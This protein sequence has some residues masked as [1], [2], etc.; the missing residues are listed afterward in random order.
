M[1]MKI[2]KWMV[3]H[4]SNEFETQNQWLILHF[5][6]YAPSTGG[7]CITIAQIIITKKIKLN[8]SNNQTKR[9]D[10]NNARSQRESQTSRDQKDT[11]TYNSLD[12]KQ[13]SPNGGHYLSDNKWDLFDNEHICPSIPQTRTIPHLS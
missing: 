5:L 10:M 9:R 13:D 8:Q 1:N 2:M 3:E 7:T 4:R 12:D 6:H 11:G